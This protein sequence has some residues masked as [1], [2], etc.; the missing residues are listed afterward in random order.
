MALRG[1]TATRPTGG[2]LPHRRQVVWIVLPAYDEELGLGALLAA[3]DDSMFQAGLAYHVVLVDDGSCDG[4]LAVAEE[5]AS[6]LP[7][8]IVRHHQN[9]GLGAAL[10]DGLMRAAELA[11][12]GDVLVTMDADQ[13]HTP[14]L[15][16]RMVQALRE[17]H[18]LIIASR[19]RPGARVKGVPLLR[20]VMSRGASVLLRALFPMR[21]VR[22]YTCGYRAYRAGV[23]QDVLRR[24]GAQ[25]FEQS[26]FQ[27]MV[28]ILLQLRPLDLICG[29][30]PLVLRYDLKR[31]PSKMP[32]ARTV[33][34]TLWLLARRRLGL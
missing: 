31:G 28:D 14:Q 3:I 11:D 30:V 2:S 22:D 12:P 19:F 23:L 25:L 8:E 27:C 26:G 21:G 7:M 33:R 17:G 6:R 5:H 18:D 24:R 34:Q 13:S 16:L 29:E 9:E 1:A 20:R 10:R 32:V 4:T 15:I